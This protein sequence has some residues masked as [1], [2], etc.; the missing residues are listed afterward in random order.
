MAVAL[1]VDQAKDE[2]IV[3]FHEAWETVGQR[4]KISTE[5]NE[6]LR[7]EMEV[8]KERSRRELQEAHMVRLM[9]LL[10]SVIHLL[11]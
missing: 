2:A 5:E 3:K 9:E 1:D 10:A 7:T 11:I 6:N 8:V 4:L